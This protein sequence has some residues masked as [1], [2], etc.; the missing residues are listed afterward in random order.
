MDHPTF[1]NPL[2]STG[3]DTDFT[4]RYDG[5]GCLYRVTVVIEYSDVDRPLGFSQFN[6]CEVLKWP[7]PRPCS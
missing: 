4:G 2:I 7:N 6:M 5:V 3:P 1:L